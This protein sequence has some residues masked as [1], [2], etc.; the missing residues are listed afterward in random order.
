MDYPVRQE[1]DRKIIDEDV[2]DEQDIHIHVHREE[3]VKQ[4]QQDI[5]CQQREQRLPGRQSQLKEL[6]MDMVHVRFERI[7]VVLDPVD[8]EPD[9]IQHRNHQGREGNREILTVPRRMVTV[10]PTA[11]IP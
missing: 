5:G 7:L 11:N 3:G 9:H 4:D 6:V 10:P 1:T 2:R 8:D